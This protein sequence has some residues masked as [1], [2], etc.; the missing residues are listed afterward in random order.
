MFTAP[1]I[2]YIKLQTIVTS[3]F[4]L[5][6]TCYLL[7]VVTFWLCFVIIEFTLERGHQG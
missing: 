1:Q 7:V 3:Y 4:L 5:L 2:T 6:A